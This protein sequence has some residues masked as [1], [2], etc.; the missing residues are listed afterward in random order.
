HGVAAGDAGAAAVANNA[1]AAVIAVVGRSLRT[2][3]DPSRL[4]TMIVRLLMSIP[5]LALGAATALSAQQPVGGTRGG[6]PTRAGTPLI[7]VDGVVVSDG[8]E[9]LPAGMAATGMRVNGVGAGRIAGLN[10]EDIDNVEILKG[11]VPAQLY[12]A[13]ATNGVVVLTTKKGHHYCLDLSPSPMA[14]DPVAARFFPPEL[15]M[16]HQR[17]LGLQDNQRAAIVNELQ[18]SQAAFVPLQWKMSAESEQLDKLLQP[19]TLNE[20]LVLAQIDRV[21]AA[22]REIKRAQIGLLIRIR[23]TLTAHQQAKLGE[24]RKS[25]R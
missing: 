2:I 4:R 11:A 24:L 1:H 13:D 23:N 22:E 9:S 8:C 7:I 20:A 5:L 12:G 21:L 14:A 19:A 18:Q 17:E 3:A 10:P 6:T 15:V 16:A 25:S